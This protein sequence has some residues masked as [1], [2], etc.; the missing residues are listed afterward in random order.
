[1]AVAVTGA[2]VPRS[3]AIVAHLAR[4]PYDDSGR[5]E[6]VAVCRES[7]D[8]ASAYYHAAW[9]TWL[10]A[11]AYA[12]ADAAAGL[13]RDRGLR[14]RAARSRPDELLPITL[15]VEAEHLVYSTCLNG[16][17]AQQGQRLRRDLE[18][19]QERAERAAE[20]ADRRDPVVRLAMAHLALTLDSVIVFEGGESSDRERVS[21]LRSAASRAGAVAGWLPEAPGPHRLL[22]IIRARLAE[23]DN[24]AIYWD[25]AIDE[26]T[27]ALELDPDDESLPELLWTL[28]LRAGHWNEARKWQERVE[29]ISSSC[30]AD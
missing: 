20:E 23:M 12:E 8:Y 19:M 28:H 3:E 2:A 15:A 30:T 10:S 14:D 5:V 11:S 6:L 7:G 13:L 17:I 29:A 1:M 25:L 27:R 26:A 18:T 16:A 21:L 4:S 24:R 22:A 9:L